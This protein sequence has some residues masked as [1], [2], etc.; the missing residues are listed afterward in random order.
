MP[1]ELTS[2]GGKAPVTAGR[3]GTVPAQAVTTD[4]TILRG[5]CSAL[6][7]FDVGFA[8]D[9]NHAQ[10]LL[11]ADTGASQ[12]EVLKHSRRAPKYF[13]YQPAPIRVARRGT[14]VTVG[15]FVTEPVLEALIY[16][17]GA[18]SI[19]FTIPL[20]GPFKNLLALSDCLYENDALLAESRRLVQELLPALTP[21]VNK[22]DVAQMVEDYLVFD[23]EEWRLPADFSGGVNDWIKA[24]GPLVARFCGPIRKR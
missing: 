16:D 24:S 4:L 15:Q 23:I 20:Q 3:Q 7:A 10:R 11:G 17:F 13:E 22:P 9:L 14:P 12:R 1:P 5:N 2:A 21:A 19:T 8:I 18:I 6:F